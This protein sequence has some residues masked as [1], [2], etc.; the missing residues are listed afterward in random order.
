VPA[1]DPVVSPPGDAA[2]AGSSHEDAPADGGPYMQRL[3]QAHILSLAETV[4]PKVK[5][6]QGR[7]MEIL[8]KNYG[9]SASVFYRARFL[10]KSASP[11]DLDAVKAGRLSINAAYKKYKKSAIS[12][13]NA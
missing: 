5:D 2:N 3:T 6:G 9:L 13:E 1:A 8:A 12:L 11:E 10:L 4:K 7:G